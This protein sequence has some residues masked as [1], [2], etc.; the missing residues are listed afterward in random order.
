MWARM[1]V[2]LSWKLLAVVLLSLGSGTLV[3]VLHLPLL[4]RQMQGQLQHLRDE[5]QTYRRVAGALQQVPPA[6]QA[7]RQAQR[8]LVARVRQ[9]LPGTTATDVYLVDMYGRQLYPAEPARQLDLQRELRRKLQPNNVI[10]PEHDSLLFFPVQ[11][12]DAGGYLLVQTPYPQYFQQFLDTYLWQVWAVGGLSALVFCGVFL[13]LQRPR[14]RYLRQLARQVQEM[15]DN[16]FEGQVTEAGHDEL[17]AVARSINEMARQLARHMAQERQNEQAR[18]ELIT[19][20]SHDLKSPLTSILGYLDLLQHHPGLHGDPTPQHYVATAH[21]K[22][23]LLNTRINRLFEYSQLSTLSE[24]GLLQPVPTNVAMLLRQLAGDFTPLFERRGIRVRLVLA[25]D[26]VVLAIDHHYWVR[27]LENLFE[28]AVRYA[29]PDSEF[30]LHLTQQPDQVLLV[31]E[32]EAER[33]NDTD[34]ERLFDRFYRGEAA[35]RSEGSGLGLAITRRILALH[36]S[37]ISAHWQ[38]RRLQ[39]RITIPQVP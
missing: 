27:A 37:S 24:R 3:F 10:V 20:L 16:R 5:Q 13:L 29:A 19:S 38:G 12:T 34:A 35:R 22:A 36:H 7:D 28:N 23:L 32:N 14:I 9:L 8:R 25:P 39:F 26:T 21:R 33:S 18:Y 4:H 2:S 15:A 6:R 31:L 11:F 17:G 30:L 1:R